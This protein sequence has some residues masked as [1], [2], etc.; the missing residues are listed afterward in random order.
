MRQGI[1]PWLQNELPQCSR[2]QTPG[3]PDSGWEHNDTVHDTFHFRTR[4]SGAGGIAIALWT[5]RS[6]V[7][8]LIGARNSSLLWNVQTGSVTHRGSFPGTKWLRHEVNHSPPSSAKVKNEWSCTSTPPI[9]LH[10]VDR[11]NFTFTLNF[12]CYT[13]NDMVWQ[14][15]TASF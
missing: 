13:I 6:G 3:P 12:R 9:C 11:A 1:S 15:W 8:V 14:S 10:G 2:S 5:G 4:V 7:R